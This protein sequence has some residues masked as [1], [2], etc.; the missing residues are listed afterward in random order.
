MQRIK[1]GSDRVRLRLAVKLLKRTGNV[2][3]CVRQE[4]APGGRLI[5]SVVLLQANLDRAV[6]PLLCNPSAQHLDGLFISL[7]CWWNDEWLHVGS[8]A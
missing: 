7:C 1:N 2:P 6:L 8:N 4:D 5:T 3:D